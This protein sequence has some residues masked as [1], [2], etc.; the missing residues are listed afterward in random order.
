MII[1]HDILTHNATFSVCSTNLMRFSNGFDPHEGLETPD[2]L[3]GEI[4]S[5]IVE[6][7]F[8]EMFSR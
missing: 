5:Q 7:I 6:Q 4:P 3:S 2:G 8:S 1:S